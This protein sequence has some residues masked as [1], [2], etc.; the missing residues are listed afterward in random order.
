MFQFNIYDKE[1]LTHVYFEG[2][3]DIEAT[4]VFEEEIIPKVENSSEV[5]INF[6]KVPFVDSSGIGLLINLIRNLQD[7]SINV[8]ISEVNPEVKTIFDLL[9]IP[10]IVGAHVFL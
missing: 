3:L 7:N 4:E 6:S 9:Q 8:N 10:D 1:G 5:T 2:D